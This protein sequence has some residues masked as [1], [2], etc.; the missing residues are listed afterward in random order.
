[1]SARSG[2]QNSLIKADVSDNTLP[3][4]LVPIF[5]FV[6]SQPRYACFLDWQIKEAAPLI[7][8]PGE[9]DHVRQTHC[10]LIYFAPV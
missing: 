6:S 10:E 8:R 7:S 3:L 4:N 1:M 5:L 2:R 9:W